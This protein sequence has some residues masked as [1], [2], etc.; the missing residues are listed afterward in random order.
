LWLSETGEVNVAIK[1]RPRRYRVSDLEERKRETVAI[2]LPVDEMAVFQAIITAVLD[3]PSNQD[4]GRAL[5]KQ[6]MKDI[7]ASSDAS[8]ALRAAG[9]DPDY[10]A[11]V[12]SGKVRA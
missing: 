12:L 9:Y 6:A 2:R 3:R 10:F 4:G 7:L 8:E 5:L 11:S 1:A